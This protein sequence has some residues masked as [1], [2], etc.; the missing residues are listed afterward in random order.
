MATHRLDRIEEEIKKELSA[1]ISDLKDPRISGLVSVVAVNVTK[2]LRYAKA[3]ISILG[4]DEDAQ[5]TIE[6]LSSAAGFIRKEIGHRIKLR[7]T[8]EFIFKEDSSIERGAHINKIIR[9]VVPKSGETDEQ[10]N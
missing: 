7:Y 5:G 10:D 6:G 3:F 9:Q 2:D 4:N 1:V 8:P